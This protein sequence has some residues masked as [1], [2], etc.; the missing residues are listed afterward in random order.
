VLGVRLL[1][2]LDHGLRKRPGKIEAGDLG[3]QEH[4]QAADG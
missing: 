3:A 1:Q 2:G 4:A